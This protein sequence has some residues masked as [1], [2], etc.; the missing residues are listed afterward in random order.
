MT[1]HTHLAGKSGPFVTSLTP[2]SGEKAE[3]LPPDFAASRL[4][5]TLDKLSALRIELIDQAF[6]L[7]RRG[8]L[9]AADVAIATASRLEEVGAELSG[10]VPEQTWAPSPDGHPDCA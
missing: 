2:V 8:Q 9:E 5:Q 10:D 3:K 7:E 4:R 1:F 6:N